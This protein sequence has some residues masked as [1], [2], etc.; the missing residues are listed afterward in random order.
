LKEYKTI[1]NKMWRIL[2]QNRVVEAK[3]MLY[4]ISSPLKSF[5]HKEYNQEW[6][7]TVKTNLNTHLWCSSKQLACNKINYNRVNSYIENTTAWFSTKT[8]NRRLLRKKNARSCINLASKQITKSLMKPANM[9]NSKKVVIIS[10][11]R[12]YSLLDRNLFKEL[13]VWKEESQEVLHEDQ[14]KIA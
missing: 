9:L 7:Q 13:L 8:S 2:L 4:S 5:N 6:H 12:Q 10:L 14:V 11:D 1:L 3:F